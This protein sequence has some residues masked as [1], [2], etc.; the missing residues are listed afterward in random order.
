MASDVIDPYTVVKLVSVTLKSIPRAPTIRD[1]FL[2]I[3]NH[4]YGKHHKRPPGIHL[5]L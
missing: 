4:I 3:P 5:A 2:V 1:I